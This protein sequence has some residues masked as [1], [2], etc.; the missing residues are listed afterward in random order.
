MM[1]KALA[2]MALAGVAMSAQAGIAVQENFNNFTSLA[3]K[4]WVFK[5]ASMPVGPAPTWSAGNFPTFPAQGASADSND[6]SYAASQ[7]TNAGDGGMLA[8]WLITPDFYAVNDVQVSFWLRAEAATGFSDQVAFGYSTGG[9]SAIGD[10]IMSAP[11]T[12][13]TDGWAQY[14]YTIHGLGAGGRARFAIEHVGAQAT[15]DYVGLDTLSVNV[16][17]PASIALVASGL[18]GLGA[19]RRRKQ[20]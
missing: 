1:K 8:N 10:F 20:G 16:P 9:S 12:V 18:L 4:G 19:L 14:T 11:V 5:N 6:N 13:G 2:T 7:F 3:G 15:S 17:E